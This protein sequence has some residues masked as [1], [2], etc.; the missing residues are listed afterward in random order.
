MTVTLG[1]PPTR[2]ER[3]VRGGGNGSTRLKRNASR[4]DLQQDRKLGP[5]AGARLQGRGRQVHRRRACQPPRSTKSL[6]KAAPG[7]ALTSTVVGI[8]GRVALQNWQRAA[9]PTDVAT[10]DENDP[11]SST[12]GRKHPRSRR[13]Q[14]TRPRARDQCKWGARQQRRPGCEVD[15]HSAS[16]DPKTTCCPRA[17]TSGR[18]VGDEPARFCGRVQL[19][20]AVKLERRR[21]PVGSTGR[22]A[23]S[24]LPSPFAAGEPYSARRRRRVG[25]LHVIGSTAEF[26]RWRRI[27]H[28]QQSSCEALATSAR[29]RVCCRLG[30]VVTSRAS[31]TRPNRTASHA[32]RAVDFNSTIPDDYSAVT[33][34]HRPGSSV[35]GG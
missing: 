17:V 5:K 25:W 9:S 12:A 10:E 7:I 35:W 20:V 34:L 15:R 8:A 30:R 27:G 32:S 33:T 1:S 16:R 11:A 28:N 14:S 26:L 3:R 18:R 29:F 4:R 2:L 13:I 23:A 6:G 21:G 19:A 22:Q 24:G 31:K